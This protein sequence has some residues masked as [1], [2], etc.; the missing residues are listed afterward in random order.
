MWLLSPADSEIG[1]FFLSGL[2]SVW[3]TDPCQLPVTEAI[4]SPLFTAD[5]ILKAFITASEPELQ[6]MIFLK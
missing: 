4:K 2:N 1:L 6:K 5:D 3:S